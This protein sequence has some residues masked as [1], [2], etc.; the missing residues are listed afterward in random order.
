MVKDTKLEQFRIAQ[1]QAFTKKQ[2][3]YQIQQNSWKNLS[4]AKNKM[5]LA[6]DS[7]QRAF[8]AQERVWQENRSVSDRNG[9]R[10]EYLKS[11]QETAYQNMKNAFSRA[12]SAYESRDGISAKS[13]ANEGHRFKDEAKGYVEERRRLVEECKDS[14][15]RHEPYKRIF[16]E[17]KIA[18]GRAKDEY[19]QAKATHERANAEFK[20]AKASFDVAAKSFQARLNELKDQS[21]K[22]KENNRSIAAKAGI[23][24]Q[25]RD[26][27]YVSEDSDGTINIFFGGLGT[28]DGFG[29]GHYT[30][31][32]SSS[33]TYKRDPFDP[34]GHQNFIDDKA[35]EYLAYDRHMR[36]DKSPIMS[37][38]T[39]GTIYLHGENAGQKVHFTQVY[40]DSYHVSWDAKPD[41]T[42]EGVHW[43]NDKLS[44][45]DPSKFLPPNDARS[46]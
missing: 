19:E 32:G 40:D 41:G 17:A 35:I 4:K 2:E 5:N 34:H 8:D 16:D 22:R 10:I 24:Y 37:G 14:R 39:N 46:F 42:I 26:N 21:T 7:K 15:A 12:T 31:D 1:E 20:H 13:N 45:G 11:A 30:M 18:F 25:Y 27:V 33:I 29:H 28:P 38:K 44:P 36:S 43:T 3:A 6:F 9:P 23:P